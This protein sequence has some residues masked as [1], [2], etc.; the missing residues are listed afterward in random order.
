MDRNTK[1]VSP[2][3]V[4]F[5]KT[6]PCV[7]CGR[8]P[9]DHDHLQARGWGSAKHNDLFSV[10]MC[11]EHHSERHAIGT[12]AFNLKYAIN[13][14]EECARLIA[15]FCTMDID[16]IEGVFSAKPKAKAEV[17]SVPII[18]DP[19]TGC[20]RWAR[21]NWSNRYPVAKIQGRAVR[22]SRYML[23]QR[24]GRP[25]AFGLCALHKCDN[26]ACI[27]G[28]H[29]FEGS[30]K[31]NAMDMVQKGRGFVPDNRGS[32]SYQAKLSD[33]II[34][35][36]RGRLAKGLTTLA[37][38]AR[39][40]GVDSNTMSKALRG[41]TWRHVPGAETMPQRFGK[42]N[43]QKTPCVNCRKMVK[44]GS[45][46]KGRC[47]TCAVYFYRTGTDRTVRLIETTAL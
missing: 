20:H 46:A 26:R 16:A 33:G 45:R 23:E 14:W 28:D 34:V 19:V 10:P 11:R 9:V 41:E 5:V 31:E 37:E 39:E 32:K 24:L 44:P 6:K 15:E 3:Y 47:H 27:N 1:I 21:S 7:V 35:E 42:A 30:K 29:L 17:G 36:S 13:L 40:Y 38:L 22:L 4:R 2:M 18:V 8:E 12:D 43:P 25:I